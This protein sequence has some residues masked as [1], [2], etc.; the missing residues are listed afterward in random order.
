MPK[1]SATPKRK[2]MTKQARLNSGVDWV[3]RYDGKNII[4]G[5]AKWFGVDKICAINELQ[6][7]G[8][9]FPAGLADQI[10]ASHKLRIKQRGIIREKNKIASTIRMESD[11][12]FAFIAGHTLGG[13][14]YGL[15]RDELK[16]IESENPD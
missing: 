7:I 10:I 9:V 16:L 3:K 13:F 6:S 4:A 1:K 2:R 14:P 8:V 11:D 15:T 5:Y 12:N